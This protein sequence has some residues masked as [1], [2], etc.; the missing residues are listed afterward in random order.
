M[1]DDPVKSPNDA[2]AAT[3]DSLTITADSLHSKLDSVKKLMATEIK[4]EG[5]SEEVTATADNQLDII[6]RIDSVEAMILS[7]QMA[8]AKNTS[9]T[10][11]TAHSTADLLSIL[12]ACR[13]AFKVLEYIGKLAKPLGYILALGTTIIGL[14]TTFRLGR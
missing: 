7:I 13:G 10:N 14:W 4:L 3:A 12:T 6:H 1:Q 11:T 5:V 9:I 2:L 8:L